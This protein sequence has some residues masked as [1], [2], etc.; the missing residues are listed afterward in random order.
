MFDE[1]LPLCLLQAKNI[2]P[3]LVCSRHEEAGWGS[4]VYICASVAPNPTAGGSTAE[5]GFHIQQQVDEKA[6]WF[7]V[8][9]V[10]MSEC[11]MCVCVCVCDWAFEQACA[12]IC[13]YKCIQCTGALHTSTPCV[14]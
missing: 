13:A 14:T 11:V 5:G 3:I 6:L 2:L 9:T 1:S 10:H 4:A 12:E 8:C 7:S